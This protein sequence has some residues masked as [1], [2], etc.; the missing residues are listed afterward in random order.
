MKK[1]LNKRL[2]KN[3]LSFA[4]VFAMVVGCSDD[5][6]EQTNNNATSSANFG[7]SP[8]QVKKAVNAAFHPL[9][10]AFSFGRVVQLG[11]HFRSDETLTIDN[12]G[13]T[14]TNSLQGAPGAR[15]AAQA[16]QEFYLTIGRSNTVI[17]GTSE[18]GIPDDTVRNN[19][20]GQAYF[21][22]A[23][24]YWNLVLLYGNVPIVLEE[25]DL[26]D[27]FPFQS[28]PAEIWP[29]II[30]DLEKAEEMLPESWSGDDLGRPTSGAATA[31]KGKS[32]LYLKDWANA[33]IAFKEVV[34]SGTYAL[35]PTAQ[36]EDNFTE[37]NE[38]NSES[39]F[40]F[41]FK[42]VETFLWG[43]DI[44]G[45]GTQGHFVIEY[46][47]PSVTP[48][49]GFIVPTWIKDLYEANGDVVRRNATI[50]YDYPDAT[51]YGGIDFLT[52]FAPDIQVAND[53]GVEP[54]F[55]KK[56]ARFE[57]TRAAA[58]ADNLGAANGTNFRIIR[59][60]D[61][62]LMLAEALNEQT[63]KTGEAEGYINQVRER[64]QIAPH[65]G[66]SQEEMR[67]AII[68]ERQMELF[69]EGHRFFDLIRWNL[70]ETYLGQNSVHPIHPKSLVNGNGFFQPGQDE[71][72][73]IPTVELNSNP[74]LK[75]NPG[76]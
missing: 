47:P 15:W 13:N 41:Q 66:L 55:G 44:P 17:L 54:I 76:Y 4:V 21:L 75:Q 46:A 30:A 14:V 62:L 40:E 37:T 10:T 36:F 58:A 24:S 68:D 29:I 34:N 32:Y 48:D 70:A 26:N 1:I 64:A 7:T 20:V 53:L 19:L 11:A 67:T 35:L 38:N 65:N 72:F 28:T 43:Q 3:V 9:T 23:F 57:M 50:V 42:G 73:W 25:P 39:I 63:G 74:N 6:L 2:S 71:L 8:T 56:Y 16:W 27:A 60:A 12:G 33:E 31:L 69:I 45:T 61:V 52:D 22:R 51:G 49:T 18:E 5:L 59:Y